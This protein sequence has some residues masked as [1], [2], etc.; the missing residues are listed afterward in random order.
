MVA[1]QFGGQLLGATM[2][3]VG[4]KTAADANGFSAAVAIAIGQSASK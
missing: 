3:E 4:D 1:A 2:G